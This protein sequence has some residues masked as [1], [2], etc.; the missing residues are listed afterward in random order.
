MRSNRDL[1]VV[2][3][4][5]AV[6]VVSI[7]G[8]WSIYSQQSHKVNGHV[9]FQVSSMDVFKNGVYNGS[10]TFGGLKTYGDFGIGTINNL[11]GEMLELAGTF[12]NIKSNGIIYI[13]ND[14]MKTPFALV[15]FFRIQ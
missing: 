9:L 1:L 8:G 7:Y 11:D 15:T 10:F 2:I 13:I 12:Y 14:T 4:I 5:A 6:L 3:S